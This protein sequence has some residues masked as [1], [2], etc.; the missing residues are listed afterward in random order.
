MNDKWEQYKAS[1]IQANEDR[2]SQYLAQPKKSK[3][4]GNQIETIKKRHPYLYKAAELLRG[5]P[6]LE[7]AGNIAGHFNRAVEGTGLPS[8]AKGLL[9]TGI[10]MSRGL[11]NLVPGVNIPK[12][13]YSEVNVNP[14]VG[15]A[16]ETIG[17]LGM[18]LPA[19]RGY[20]ATKKGLESLPYAKKVPELIRNVLAGGTLGSS[21]SP[22][23]RMIG[24]GLGSA[25]EVIPTALQ[26][27]KNY[28]QNRNVS[29]KQRDY[30]KALYEHE[31]QNAEAQE[32]KNQISQIPKEG[33]A[34]PE[35][36]EEIKKY[37]GEGEPNIQDL[38]R[39]IVESIEGTPVMEPHPKTG[40]PR[41]VRHGGLREEIGKK[42]DALEESLPEVNIPI[43]DIKSLNKALKSHFGKSPDVTDSDKAAFEKVIAPLYTKNKQINGKE[44]FRTYRSLRRLE[45]QER[46]K[47]FG[48]DPKAHDEWVHRADKT[49]KNYEQMEKI[50][51]QHF[52]KNTL[53][54][55][56]EI[57]HEYANKVAPLHD[58]P[59]YQQMLKHGRYSGDVIESLSG[60]TSGNKI[61]TNL[62]QN[63]PEL[64]KLA[65]AHS[66]AENP[67][68]LLKP[69]K[70]IE[71][72]IKSN[73]EIGRLID[74][75]KKSVFQLQEKKRRLKEL[76]KHELELT[77]AG[78]V[79]VTKRKDAIAKSEEKLRKSRNKMIGFLL[80]PA[81]LKYGYNKITE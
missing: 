70:L 23:N 80:G 22:D 56:H 41:E 11:A 19:Y 29:A 37:L 77:R 6:G 25:G 71:P 32:L 52:P 12:Q 28:I 78:K 30:Y 21:I 27:A 18:G 43:T 55:L 46:S 8:A 72:Y 38:S 14:Y 47:A 58:N 62:I 63:N 42:Y 10:D 36:N 4:E 53:K 17:S 79:E 60:T 54:S 59:L 67:E 16:A 3:K 75:Q 73:P 26:G 51:E 5:T 15:E 40:L 35:I 2:W 7:T 74:E 81:A 39:H 61:I 20:Q 66:F 48:L 69:N 31:M 64:S 24:A 49:K 45:G 50:I 44:F 76:L 57:N 1:G 9:G 13:Q 65:L 33:K 34:S 68:K